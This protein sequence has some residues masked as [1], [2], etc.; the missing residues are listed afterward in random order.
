MIA[1]LS[2]NEE[3]AFVAGFFMMRQ[4]QADFIPDNQVFQFS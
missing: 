2:G 3:P 4:T 1:G